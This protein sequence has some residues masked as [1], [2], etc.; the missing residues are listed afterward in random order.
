MRSPLVDIDSRPDLE[1]PSV[2]SSTR[3][4]QK[5]GRTEGGFKKGLIY[6]SRQAKT[7]NDHTFMTVK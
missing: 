7:K 3:T 6:L 5:D 2:S 4:K 1:L